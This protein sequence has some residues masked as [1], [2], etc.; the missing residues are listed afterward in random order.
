VNFGVEVQAGDKFKELQKQNSSFGVGRSASAIIAQ[1]E[2]L[3]MQFSQT[4][5]YANRAAKFK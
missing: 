2:G 1:V 5:I 4:Q 3:A